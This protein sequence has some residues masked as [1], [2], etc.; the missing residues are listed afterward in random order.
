MSTGERGKHDAQV[1]ADSDISAKAN[2][3]AA[4][5]PQRDQRTGRACTRLG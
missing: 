1:S 5:N 4:D 3:A 2:D